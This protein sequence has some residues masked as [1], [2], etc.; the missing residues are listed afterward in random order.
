MSKLFDPLGIASKVIGGVKKGGGGGRGRG[1]TL[2]PSDQRQVP[3]RNLQS[4]Y[5]SEIGT[6]RVTTMLNNKLG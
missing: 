4:A 5:A 6:E 3:A 1:K 2:L